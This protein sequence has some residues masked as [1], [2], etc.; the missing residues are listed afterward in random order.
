MPSL[1]LPHHLNQPLTL[2][3]WSSLLHL[4][5]SWDFLRALLLLCLA[6]EL[7]VPQTTGWKPRQILLCQSWALPSTLQSGPMKC[8]YWRQMPTQK[9]DK[10]QNHVKTK[11]DMQLCTGDSIRL[12]WANSP[13]PSLA[14]DKV[15]WRWFCIWSRQILYKSEVEIYDSQDVTLKCS[16]QKLALDLN[17]AMLL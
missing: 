15:K 11:E 8:A 3:S 16:I 9:P 12:H 17:N 5:P 10:H 7:G 6:S 2:L 4:Y 1:F 14:H 13:Y